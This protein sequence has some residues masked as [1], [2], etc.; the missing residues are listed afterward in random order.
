MEFKKYTAAIEERLAA[1]FPS[2]KQPSELYE[3]IRYLLQGG[4][5]RVRPLLVLLAAESVGGKVPEAIPAAI[6]VELFHNSTLIHDDIMD[7]S[8]VRRGRPTVHVQYNESTAILCGDVMFGIAMKLVTQSAVNS[9]Q[10]HTVYE[11]F[12]Q[13]FIDV[14][15]G[16]ALDMAFAERPNVSVEEYFLMTEF[17]TAR[18]LEACVSIGAAIANATPAQ[19]EA[20]QLFA[21][22]VGLAFQMQDDIL[23]LEGAEEFGKIPGGDVIE[24]KQTWLVLRAR[25]VAGKATSE[26]RGVIDDFFNQR[27]LPEH[28]VHE[29]RACIEG[30]GVLDEARALVQHHTS[31]ATNHLHIL[32]ESAARTLLERLATQLIS[33]ST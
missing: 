6:A 24:G 8:A 28:R 16:Q 3:P 29:M 10:P 31:E 25:E 26:W 15:E 2:N 5:K 9:S 22:H 17:K 33:R 27:G 14:C 18:L 32:P 30:L 1:E 19:S 11:A 12:A 21:R 13:G 23:D 4:G 20:L 7:R